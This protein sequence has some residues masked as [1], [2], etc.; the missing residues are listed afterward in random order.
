MQKRRPAKGRLFNFR[1]TAGQANGEARCSIIPILIVA[2]T[3]FAT[4]V[5]IPVAAASSRNLSAIRG[6]LFAPVV[7]IRN[8]TG[9]AAWFVRRRSSSPHAE[10]G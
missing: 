5:E 7:A 3:I 2:K 1:S 9:S 8:S 4:A 10:L 6:R